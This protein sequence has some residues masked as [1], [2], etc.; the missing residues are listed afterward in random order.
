MSANEYLGELPAWH[1]RS[2]YAML[3]TSATVICNALGIDFLGFLTGL[4][5]G[6]NEAEIL[7][8][9]EVVMPLLFALWAWAERRAPK[10]RLV[11]RRVTG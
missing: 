1:A 3:L 4:G 7:N 11:W 8:T 2:F 5:L 6:E 9:I 10:F